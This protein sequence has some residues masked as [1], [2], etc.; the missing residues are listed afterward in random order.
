MS[1]NL[2]I[3]G[4]QERVLNSDKLEKALSDGCD[5]SAKFVETLPEKAALRTF[6]LQIQFSKISKLTVLM[7]DNF[8]PD[9]FRSRGNHER[10]A[11]SR[12]RSMLISAF[13]SVQCLNDL[14]AEIQRSF[15]SDAKQA[16]L[17][18]ERMKIFNDNLK[19][20]YYVYVTH[21]LCEVH[22]LDSVEEYLNGLEPRGLSKPEFPTPRCA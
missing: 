22:D 21:G 7:L 3:F 20:G 11:D 9:E 16:R 13:E 1:K 14:N 12:M 5:R 19:I 17:A 10:E 15:P 4:E 8:S 18:S 2:H 6:H